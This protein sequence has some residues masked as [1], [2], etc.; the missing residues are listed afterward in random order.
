MTHGAG[1][2]PEDAYHDRLGSLRLLAISMPI[3]FA[4]LSPAFGVLNDLSRPA[5]ERWFLFIGSVVFVV[6][7]CVFGLAPA[8]PPGTV[9]NHL[10]GAIHKLGARNH[11]EAVR[12]AQQKGWL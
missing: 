12:I 2:L 1:I 5:A 8:A 7:T 10:S 9:R 3:G 11:A 6:V 4:L